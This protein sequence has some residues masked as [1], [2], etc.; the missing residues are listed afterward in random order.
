MING[1]VIGIEG[2]FGYHSHIVRFAVPLIRELMSLVMC[3]GGF[4]LL[5]GPRF[6]IKK[7]NSKV[8][9]PIFSNLLL[10]RGPGK[11]SEFLSPCSTKRIHRT[12]LPASLSI[13]R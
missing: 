4:L 11:L 7:G 10:E 12:F 1:F 2:Y 5:Q 3:L 8:P 6:L 13:K 9:Y